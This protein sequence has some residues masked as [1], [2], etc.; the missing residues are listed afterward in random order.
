MKVT[1]ARASENRDAIEKAAAALVRERGFDQMSVAQVAAAAGL[2]HGALY[3]HYASKEALSRAA[4]TRAFEETAR[5]LAGLSPAE[6]VQRYLS[7]S[8]RDHPEAGCPNAAL[9][10][11]AWR[12]SAG[13]R[14]AFRDGIRCYVE[15][16][17][18]MLSSGGEPPEK[19]KAVTVLAAMVG[20]MALAR[21]IGDIDPS[22]SNEILSD[23][24]A[25]LTGFIED[26]RA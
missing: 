23:V 5:G 16:V 13:T 7:P 19:G 17:A 25:Q 20:A 11:E 8:H 18:T 1:K 9:A 4:T 3:S 21:A 24:A 10:C 26:K 2:T 12:Q 15:L 14:E 22:F 6:F